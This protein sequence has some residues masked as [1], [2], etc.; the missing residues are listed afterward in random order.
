MF[1]RLKSCSW[2]LLIAL[3]ATSSA[4]TTNTSRTI[5]VLGDSVSAGYGIKSSEGWVTLLSQKLQREG[6]GYR[7][8][9]ASVTGE[10]T[11][12]GLTRLPRALQIHRPE[13]VILELGGN[14][15]LRGLPLTATRGNLDRMIGL[16][17]RAGARVLLVGMKIPPNYGPRYTLG[18]ERIFSDL[19][20]QHS[21]PLVPFLMDRVALTPGLM[22]EDGIHPKAAGQ[23]LMLGN[24]WPQ[25]APM[26][27]R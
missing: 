16:S 8:V 7:V 14:D 20:K 6:Y 15:G 4:S 19:A 1:S 27:R 17:Q 11:T 3:V 13:I 24:V 10:T 25:L 2:V 22:Q 23:P 5:L 26:L 12:G 18:F 9:N 21:L